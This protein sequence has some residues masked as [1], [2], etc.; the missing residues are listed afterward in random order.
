MTARTALL[1]L[2]PSQF[3]LLSPLYISGCCQCMDP[4]HLQTWLLPVPA[5]HDA[6]LLAAEHRE[7]SFRHGVLDILN[8]THARWS[9]NRN[10]DGVSTYADAYFIERLVDECAALFVC[11]HVC[12]G[13]LRTRHTCRTTQSQATCVGIALYL[14]L[15]SLRLSP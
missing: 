2:C 13:Q 11:A 1:V 4:E 14:C 9:W 8:Q 10:Q 3:F 5:K 6:L 15:H 7:P 12:T